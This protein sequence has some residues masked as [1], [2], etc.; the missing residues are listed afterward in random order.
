MSKEGIRLPL[1]FY[2]KKK[3][4]SKAV[5]A[6]RRNCCRRKRKL[7][8]KPFGAFDLTK[9]HF[10]KSVYLRKITLPQLLI[11]EIEWWERRE[12]GQVR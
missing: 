5:W 2:Y 9:T 12:I 6:I 10:V 7:G 8:I 3:G 1:Y 11:E 4:E